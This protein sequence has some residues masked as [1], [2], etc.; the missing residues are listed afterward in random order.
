MQTVQLMKHAA[1]LL[2][3]LLVLGAC[4]G[5]PQTG[6]TAAPG[7][8]AVNLTIEP[9]PIVA[10]HAS[11]NMYNFPFEVIVRETGGRPITVTSVTAELFGPGGISVGQE[12]WDAGRIRGMG[13]NTNVPANGELRYRFSPR[14]EVP[15]ER[16]FGSVRATLRV[17]AVDDQG[18]RTSASIPV[19]VRKG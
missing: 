12:S 16:L 10:T 18:A 6:V 8:G 2:S 3:A 13:Y 5:G 9:N 15:D 14:R 1:F 7:A 17:E 4:G 11:G 19:G